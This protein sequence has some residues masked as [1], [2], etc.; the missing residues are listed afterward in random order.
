MYSLH[1][2]NCGPQCTGLCL[3]SPLLTVCPTDPPVA[4]AS[5]SLAGPALAGRDEVRLHCAVQSNPPARIEWRKSGQR[6]LL[7]T[8][9]ELSLGKVVRADA[10]TYSCIARN[11]L[12]V[13]EP[14]TIAVE[15]HC[16]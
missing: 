2:G 9:P 11:E 7:G 8:Q 5:S 12:G 3:L 16:E 14:A 15:T 1:N 4:V 10:G 13:S 6:R